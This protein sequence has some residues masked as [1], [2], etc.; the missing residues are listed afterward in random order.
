RL[1]KAELIER[2]KT[3][4]KEKYVSIYPALQEIVDTAYSDDKE[5]A[6][7]LSNLSL[8]SLEFKPVASEYVQR[9]IYQSGNKTNYLYLFEIANKDFVG[10]AKGKPNIHTLYFKHLFSEANLK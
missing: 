9:G 8:Y 4:L 3:L 6:K 7:A 2:V 1:S 10:G 5:L